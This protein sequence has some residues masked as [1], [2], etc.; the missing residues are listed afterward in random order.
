MKFEVLIVDD[1]PVVIL[2][3]EKMVTASGFHSKP[4]C[5]SSGIS[6]L[7]YILTNKDPDKF[8]FILLDIN[9][10]EMSGWDF[11]DELTNHSASNQ[12][13]VAIVTSSTNESD[14]R[15]AL[16]YKPVTEYIAKPL[17]IAILHQLKW[18]SELSAFFVNTEE[19]I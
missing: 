13:I 7:D 19:A 1:D 15:R 6:A 9:M 2:L 8:Y 17:S 18:N 11:L 12:V 5:F 14:K 10:P 3:H 16:N 4:I